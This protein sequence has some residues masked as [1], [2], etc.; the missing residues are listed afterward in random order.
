MKLTFNTLSRATPYET[1]KML[2]D[3]DDKKNSQYIVPE[4]KTGYPE[5]KIKPSAGLFGFMCSILP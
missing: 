2:A 5:M 3:R 1:A 4:M